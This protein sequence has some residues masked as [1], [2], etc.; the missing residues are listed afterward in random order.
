VRT[1]VIDGENAVGD[2]WWGDRPADTYTTAAYPAPMIKLFDS[3][4]SG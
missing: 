2:G 3:P 4:V 1:L